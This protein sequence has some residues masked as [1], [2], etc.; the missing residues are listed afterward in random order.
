M[1]DLFRLPENVSTFGASIDFYFLLILAITGI[2]FVAVEVLLVLFIIRY[3]RRPGRTATYS[4]GNLRLEYIWTGATAVIVIAIAL[5]TRGLWMDIKDPARFP[6]PDLALDVTAKQFEWEVRYPGPDGLLGTADDV[7]RRNQMHVPV[8]ANVV[9]TLRSEDVIHSF[10][11]PQLRLK[12]DAVPGMEIPAWFQAT[13]AGEYPIGCAELCGMGHYRMAGTLFV[14]E[15]A[16]FDRWLADQYAAA[17]AAG[18]VVAAAA[19]GDGVTGPTAATAAH[20]H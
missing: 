17:A 8:G 1:G 11:V 15:R 7:V 14:L 6:A 16:E 13:T 18:S 19:D 20:G 12:Q 2:V 3:R 5:A 4:H 10:Y 9:F